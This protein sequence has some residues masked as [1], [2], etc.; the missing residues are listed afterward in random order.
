VAKLGC[1]GAAWHVT[2]GAP[3]LPQAN[4]HINSSHP[5][6]GGDGD[7]VPD[8]GWRVRVFSG[9]GSPSLY[10]VCARHV[11]LSY[12][13]SKPVTTGTGSESSRTKTRNVGCGRRHVVGGG[14]RLSGLINR[15]R[16]VASGPVD[17]GDAD[18]IPDDRWLSK[19]YN[20]GGI[21]TKL[22]GF[23]ICLG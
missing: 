3:F 16:L 22:T 23:A 10:V 6:D 11:D 18:E 12:R 14:A 9:T 21:S 7:R 2:T 17:A 13:K 1:G 8:D 15:G 4:N 20:L 5:I 19:A